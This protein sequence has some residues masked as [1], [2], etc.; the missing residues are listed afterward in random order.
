MGEAG[1][2][3]L[4]YATSSFYPN[5]L[6]PNTLLRYPSV[7]APSCLSERHAGNDF[8]NLFAQICYN[9]VRKEIIYDHSLHNHTHSPLIGLIFE[10]NGHEVV[11]YF[12]EEKAA[13]AAVTRKATQTP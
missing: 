8:S 3:R 1:G 11:R 5:T 9:T 10:E 6:Y 12:T 4:H 13:D 2:W 7:S